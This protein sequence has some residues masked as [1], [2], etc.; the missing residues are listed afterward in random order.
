[1]PQAPI[2]S[3]EQTYTPPLSNSP[4][5][6]QQQQRTYAR[7]VS[8]D[9]KI[10]EEQNSPLKS[11]INELKTLITQLINQNTMI[12]SMLTTLVNKHR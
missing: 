9:A 10:V 7:V 6:H 2:F 8:N 11:L 1:M 5:P 12:L 4:Q 3:H